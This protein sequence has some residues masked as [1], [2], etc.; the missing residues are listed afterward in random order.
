LN[1]PE[2]YLVV[3]D[4]AG[5]ADRESRACDGARVRDGARA[6]IEYFD[7]GVRPRDHAEIVDG[8][9]AGRD[10]TIVAAYLSVRADGDGRDGGI[11]GGE[12]DADAIFR[13]DRSVDGDSQAP[14]LAS[15]APKADAPVAIR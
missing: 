15:N 6:G 2:F 7:A 8:R 14:V 4:A 5:V 3:A 10:D 12:E 9:A 13:E 11:A 1:V